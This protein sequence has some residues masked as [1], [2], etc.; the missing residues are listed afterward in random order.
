MST[1]TIAKVQE[2]G[3]AYDVVIIGSLGVNPGVRLVNN[4]ADPGIVEEFT[5]A[6]LR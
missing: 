5:R 1:W 4:A 2:G 3:R 6:F